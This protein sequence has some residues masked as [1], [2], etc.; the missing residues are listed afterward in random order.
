MKIHLAVLLSGLL[1]AAPVVAYEVGDTLSPQTLA[2]LNLEPGKVAVLDF[3]ASWCVSC[4]KEIPELK[5]FI[6]EDSSNKV[7]VVG[8]G[9]DEVLADGLA[10]QKKL[11]IDFQVYNDMDQK[12][13]EAFGPIGMPAL[14]YVIDNK[15]VGK[16]I[17]A[18]NHKDDQ[19]RAD[20]KELG[21]DL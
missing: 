20:L 1:M 17:G 15:I 3:F 7:Q 21:V 4:A 5:Q 13:V 19:I 18:I 11:D 8:V 14:Y 12:V 2:K 6:K 10:F 9:V 16:R